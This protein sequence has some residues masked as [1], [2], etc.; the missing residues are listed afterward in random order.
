[1]LVLNKIIKNI[2]NNLNIGIFFILS[3]PAQILI[4]NNYDVI[5]YHD[6]LVCFKLL[7][8]LI[9]LFNLIRFFSFVRKFY[10]EYLLNVLIVLNILL[11]FI[12]FRNGFVNFEFFFIIQVI[13]ISIY[14]YFFSKI[15][16]YLYNFY[17]FMRVM[18]VVLICITLF[19]NTN[20]DNFTNKNFFKYDYFSDLKLNKKKDVYLIVPDGMMGFDKLKENK[21]YNDN[22]YENILKDN[23]L[24]T[25]KSLSNYPTTFAS[26]PSMLNGSIFKENTKVNEKTF[27]RLNSRSSSVNMFLNNNYEILWFENT[28]AGTKCNNNRLTCPQKK[29]FLN[30]ADN[31][32]ILEYFK[33]ININV[34]WSNIIFKALNIKRK[35]HLNNIIDILKVKKFNKPVFVFAHILL[36]HP[37]H[38]V[39]ENCNPIYL[40]SE[41]SSKFSE[42]K[43]FI[44][45]ECLKKQ[46]INFNNFVK[47]KN[48]PYVLIFASDTGWTFNDNQNPTVNIETRWKK[49][50]FQN[51]I[52]INDDNICFDKNK[53]ITNVEILLLALHCAE[54]KSLPPL[55]NTQFDAYYA[56]T[57]HKDSERLIKR[58]FIK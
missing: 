28:W 8:I 32:I 16:I 7:L 26:I 27:Y 36:P 4:L 10:F 40:S 31:E 54:N 18:S 53:I 43:Y 14:F 6:L 17:K 58:N 12:L 20:Q 15:K 2:Y 41:I 5:S 45:L 1:M 19:K 55:E 11:N 25:L 13:I 37:P 3:I 57:G 46:I 34:Y 24:T 44:Q 56:K 21:Y 22:N 49:S 39:D 50:S 51:N 48:R 23:N 42:K 52:I 47:S 38:T 33:I 30:F 9:L 35:N 29:N